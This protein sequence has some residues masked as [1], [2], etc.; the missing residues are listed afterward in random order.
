MNYSSF[1]YLF[2]AFF[3]CFHSGPVSAADPKVEL[4]WTFEHSPQKYFQR[5]A[6]VLSESLRKE[7]GDKIVVT[8]NSVSS[9]SRADRR[10]LRQRYLELI[11]N[12]QIGL[13]QIYL[14][15]ISEE[16][17]LFQ[18]LDM[19]FLFRDHNHVTEVVEGPIGKKLLD[20]LS[21]LGLKGLALTYSGGHQTFLSGNKVNFLDQKPFSGKVGGGIYPKNAELLGAKLLDAAN[22]AKYLDQTSSTHLVGPGILDFS[23]ITYA[24]A[25]EI[26]NDYRGPRQ[27]YHYNANFNVLFTALVMNKDLFDSLP[28]SYQSAIQKAATLAARAEREMIV[29][30]SKSTQEKIENGSMSNSFITYV[31][32][33]DAELK[34]LTK[35]AEKASRGFSKE[36][37]DMVKKIKESK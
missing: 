35:I 2:L 8:T 7:M 10:A 29:T 23:L 12:N 37:L 21:K 32:L 30:D 36:Q 5:A 1:L 22:S 11:R 28:E 15:Q 9:Q 17:K 14:D 34:S 20:R 31:K 6:D 18:V 33:S 27:I 4:K 25:D 26:Y 3:L 19:P 24:D 13:A 16:D